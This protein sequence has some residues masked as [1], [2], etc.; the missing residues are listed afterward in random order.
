MTLASP[1]LMAFRIAAAARRIADHG[2]STP[3]LAAPALSAAA[4]K[5]VLI[6]S[7]F[8]QPTGSFKVRGA[9]NA[10]AAR[11]IDARARGVITFST[12]NHGRAL[13]WAA[14]ALD[15]SC[16]VFVSRL[17]PPYKLAALRATGASVRI[18]G[19]SQDE[20]E[21]QA[22]HEAEATGALMISPIHDPEV[23]SG[24]ATA[25]IEIMAQ[26]PDVGTVIVP[27]SAGGLAA[28]IAL[29]ARATA[30]SVRLVG[31][32]MEHGAAMHASLAAGRPVTVREVASLADSLGG[33]IGGPDSPTFPIVRD[34]FDDL[35]LVSETAIGAAMVFA[36]RHE[37]IL[38]EG[39][40]A[41][42]L[43]LVLDPRARD[44]PEPLV[45]LATGGNVDPA[46]VDQLEA[47]P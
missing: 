39:A 13:G 8:L 22:W 1:E 31:V 11:V 44:F 2:L 17:V 14:Q 46:V 38:L 6:K 24:H 28:G 29:A 37:N 18:V 47:R 20:A 35:L 34:G 3:L 16:T 9:Y 23:A 7:E 45:L 32:S 30:P 36:R 10:V 4:G 40:A 15:V 21:A 12:G 33:G 41:T 27:V 19:D 43:A 5:T 26:C 25:M 42:T